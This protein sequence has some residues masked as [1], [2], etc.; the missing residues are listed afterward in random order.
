MSRAGKF[1]TTESR[2]AY[3]L[4]IPSAVFLIVFMFYPIFYVFLMSLFKVNKLANLTGFYGM[5][6]FITLF[7]LPEFWQIIIRSCIWTALAVTAKTVIGLIIALLLNVDFRGRKLARTLII[8]PWA[9]SVPISA[10]LW[11]WTYNNDF[12]LLNY[13]LRWLGLN[14]QFG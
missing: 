11:Q 13:T 3:L 2:L 1:W 6:N 10:M 4:L 14:P 7:K 8:I 9:S 5:G 12:G